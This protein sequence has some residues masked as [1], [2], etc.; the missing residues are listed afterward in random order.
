MRSE[1]N[2]QIQGVYSLAT[3][4][5]HCRADSLTSNLLL[6]HRVFTRF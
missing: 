3:G 1:Q 4:F 6:T 2:S 5:L